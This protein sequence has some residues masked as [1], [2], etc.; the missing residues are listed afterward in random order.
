MYLKLNLIPWIALANDQIP[1]GV[2]C[3]TLLKTQVLINILSFHIFIKGL[4]YYFVEK[5]ILALILLPFL[6]FRNRS[7][8]C[9][10]FVVVVAAAVV[11]VI[12]I[13]VARNLRER[14]KKGFECW[15][16]L[17]TWEIWYPPNFHHFSW[18]IQ[19]LRK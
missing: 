4:N 16:Y 7:W 2:P 3:L 18:P 14:V 5:M 8:R 9:Y 11:V 1:P 17:G 12:I 15:K 19:T 6:S 10:Y 13:V